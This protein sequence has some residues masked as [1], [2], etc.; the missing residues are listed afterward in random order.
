MQWDK[1]CVLHTALG[2]L[3]WRQK[4]CGAE[5]NRSGSGVMEAVKSERGGAQGDSAAVPAIRFDG[6]RIAFVVE[7]GVF[8][9]V[10]RV[11]LAVA[12]GEFVA[13]VGPTGCGKSTLLNA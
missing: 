7:G 3:R 1:S 12:D 8:T 11:D 4:Q 9:A 10:D 5:T 13:I 2:P 6:V